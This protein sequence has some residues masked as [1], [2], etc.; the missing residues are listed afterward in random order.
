MGDPDIRQKCP[1]RKVNPD[2]TTTI[3]NLPTISLDFY[4][5]LT[6][7]YEVVP[8]VAVPVYLNGTQLMV[9]GP[10]RQP[11]SLYPLSET[12]YFIVEA[13]IQISFLKGENGEIGYLLVIDG[14]NRTK[15]KK[16]E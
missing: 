8:G 12:E 13:N 5:K 7:K 3:E 1:I 10:N 14:N 6:G 2:L 11:Y 4:K 15:A 16:V 9:V